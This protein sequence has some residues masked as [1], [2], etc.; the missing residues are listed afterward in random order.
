MARS[1][2]PEFMTGSHQTEQMVKPQPK[3]PPPAEFRADHDAD[4]DS[5]GDPSEGDNPS[6]V[7]APES[8]PKTFRR[9]FVTDTSAGRRL[10]VFLSLRFSDW[11]R[12]RIARAITEGL[13]ISE[14]RP[15]KPST[16]LKAGE[17]LRV[18]IPGIAPQNTAPPLPPILYEDTHLLLLNKPPGM[19]THPS[20]QR[21]EYAVIGLVREAR[22]DIRPA[23]AHRLDRD[24]SGVLVL[25]KTDVANRY[26]KDAFQNRIVSKSYLAIVRGSVP[27]EEE[28]ADGPIGI[29]GGTLELRR[30]VR[31]DGDVAQTR[32]NV[33]QRLQNHTL[34]QC[35][36]LTGRTHQIRVHLESLGF[37]ILGDKI[38]GQP[39]DIFLEYM[40]QG[41][42]E[43]VRT[44]VGFPRQC[45]HAASIAFPHPASGQILKVNAP[46][47]EDMQ[48]IVDGIPPQWPEPPS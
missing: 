19:L 38:Y 5:S 11:S 13:V 17:V 18:Y 39:D 44:T 37:P 40:A 10:D 35:K 1:L 14:D 43:R 7:H 2:F 22:P 4:A 16:T 20:G 23:L 3:P 28:I 34:V 41:I 31:P 30:A 26:M 48:N 36:P 32:V 47:P 46:L 27:W 45:L 9:V 29:C 42:T 6:E 21:W 33:V 12:T 15:L 8:I 25:T 24:T